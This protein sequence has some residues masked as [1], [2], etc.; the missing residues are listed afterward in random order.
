[1]RFRTLW[2]T[3]IVV[4]GL[5]VAATAALL[6]SGQACAQQQP[7]S[8]AEDVAPIFRG[9]CASC[10]L[11]GGRG[12]N[13]S[14]FNVSSYRSVMAGTKFGRMVIPGQPDISN[15]VVLVEGRASPKIQM[16][17]EHHPL[18]SCLSQT[19]WTWVFQGAKNN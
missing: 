8:Y 17:Y 7:V 3:G 12:Y 18:P 19:I 11:P 2:L 16:P 10:H 4:S 13:A 15:L 14:G 1:M 5:S 9:Y 6:S